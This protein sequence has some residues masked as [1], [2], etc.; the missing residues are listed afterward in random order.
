MSFRNMKSRAIITGII[1]ALTSCENEKDCCPHPGPNEPSIFLYSP[2][3]K[4]K[5]DF[6][7]S[8]GW[9]QPSGH[10][11]PTD[12]IYFWFDQESADARLPVYAP[13]GGLINQ[14]LLVPVLDI[15]EC[16]V[17]IKMNDGFM[18]Y[19]DHIVLHDSLKEGATIKAGQDIGTTGLGRSIDLGAID[20]SIDVD[21]ANP[22]RYN[23]ET[24]HCGKPLAYYADSLKSFMYALVDREGEDKDGRVCVDVDG[25]LVGNWFLDGENFY[26]DGPNGWDK[27][28][29]FAFDIQH[30]DRV[31]VSIG[32]TVGLTGKWAIP[33][34]APRPEDVSVSTEKVAYRLMY[35]EGATQAGLMIVQM[36]D[37]NHIKIEVFPDSQATDADFDSNAKVYAR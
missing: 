27:E 2:I 10:T 6:I 14:I 8:L 17:W 25:K 9:I 12:H 24:L 31:L 29:S 7:L 13:G 26:T 22:A 3:E 15:P 19:L 32:G 35:M 20:Y 28:L 33:D 30:P 11:I 36:I 5:I 23:D 18:Y 34:D 4:S 1:L 21:F 16:K 37:S